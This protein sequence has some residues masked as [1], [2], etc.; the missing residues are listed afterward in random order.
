MTPHGLRIKIPSHYLQ[1]NIKKKIEIF[2][3]LPCVLPTDLKD[4]LASNMSDG[5]CRSEICSDMET[6]RVNI[7]WGGSCMEQVNIIHSVSSTTNYYHIWVTILDYLNEILP[8]LAL[9]LSCFFRGRVFYLICL[10]YSQ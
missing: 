8:G 3:H 4:I 6:D 1:F 9:V 7:G 2:E 10:R 5:Y